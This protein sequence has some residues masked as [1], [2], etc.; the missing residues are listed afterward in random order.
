MAEFGNTRNPILE[1]VEKWIEGK[2]NKAF[3]HF[4]AKLFALFDDFSKWSI[5][6]RCCRTMKNHQI[7]K[8]MWQKMQTTFLQPIF[9]LIPGTQKSN[10]EYPFHHYSTYNNANFLH[11]CGRSAQLFKYVGQN[12][13]HEKE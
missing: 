11:F 9:F 10:F 5:L 2:L 12:S 1:S 4:L 6:Q 7:W 8:K 13:L 3:L